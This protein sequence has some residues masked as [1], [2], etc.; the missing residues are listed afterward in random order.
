LLVSAPHFQ[1]ALQKPAAVIFEH[2]SSHPGGKR[3]AAK[4]EANDMQIKLKKHH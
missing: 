3:K 4:I 2:R 1:I